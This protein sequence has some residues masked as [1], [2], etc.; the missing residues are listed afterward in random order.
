VAI[1]EETRHHLYQRL[2]EALGPEEATTL[3]E[4]LPPV[5]WADVATKHDLDHLEARMD[6][7]FTVMEQ[8][9]ELLELRFDERLTRGL[10]ALEL[11]LLGAFG[12]FKDQH[13]ADQRAFQRQ[14]ILV[15]VVTVLSM[16]AA[17]LGLR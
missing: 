14:V 2:E 13:H 17:T 15:L 6:H 10:G 7:R 1:T 3:M 11:R 9:F 12:E 4:H 8:R 5:G 16:F